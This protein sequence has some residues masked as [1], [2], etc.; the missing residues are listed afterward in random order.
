MHLKW[1]EAYSCVVKHGQISSAAEEMHMTQST[2]SRQLASL[3]KFVGSRLLVR[4]ARG[5]RLTPAGRIVHSRAAHL[6]DQMQHLK[7]VLA[8]ERRGSPV[9]RMGIPPSLPPDWIRERVNRLSDCTVMLNEGTTNE[10]LELLDDAELDIAITHERS[11]T[12]PSRLALTQALGVAMP[13]T[14]RLRD[15]IG[16]DGTLDVRSLT[17]ARLMAHAQASIRSSE[18]ALKSLV[19]S[20]DAEVEWVFRRFGEHGDL[21]AEMAD[22]DGAMTIST[23]QILHAPQWSWFPLT[24]QAPHVEE[25]SVRTWI[26]WRPDAPNHIGDCIESLVHESPE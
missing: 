12:L 7:E 21:I 26:N 9:V 5:V 14:S 20:A 25:L 2:L 11:A 23:S 24:S 16:D 19:E 6:L 10:L 22:A 15:A 1:L 3:E 18:G 4:D 17:G 13:A 8:A